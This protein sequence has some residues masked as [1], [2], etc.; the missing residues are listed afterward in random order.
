MTQTQQLV[1]TAF[2]QLAWQIDLVLAPLT[3]FKLGGAAELFLELDDVS[4]LTAIRAFCLTNKIPF[5]VVGGMS[6]VIVADHGVKGVVIKLLNQRIEQS[7]DQPGVVYAGA[8]VKMPLLVAETVKY[9][10]TG[11]EYFLGVPG[12]VGGA[13]FNNAHYLSDLMSQHISRVEILN[14]EGQVEWLGV[15]E[16]DFGYDH[17][18]FQKSGEVILGVEFTLRPGDP[19]ISQQLIAKATHYRASTQPLGMPSSGC[20]FQNVP[21]TPHLQQLFPQFAEKTHVPG[22]FLIDQAGLKG[23][24]RGSLEVSQKHA[25]FIVNHGDGSSRDLLELI[26]HIKNTVKDKFAVE[27]QEEVFFLS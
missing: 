16:C 14:V 24:R 2:P 23:V 20:I 15:D 12:S 5:V 21:N 1:T 9:G 26:E 6:N 22:G 19:V 7:L 25:A 27:L 10:L 18:R 17:S 8:G 13:V 4:A 11:L 3:Y